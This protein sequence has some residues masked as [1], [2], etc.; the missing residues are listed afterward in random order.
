MAS[1][2]VSFRVANTMPIVMVEALSTNTLGLLSRA[3]TQGEPSPQNVIQV[4]VDGLRKDRGQVLCALY[5]SAD[6]FPKKRDKALARATS[7]ISNGHAACEFREA[8][9]GTYAVSVFHDEN[10]NEKLDTN[11]LGTPCEGVGASNNAKGHLGPP[12]FDQ[13]AF[14]FPG[15]RLVLKITI[16]YL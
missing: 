3:V 9:A 12:K 7:P 13:A 10:S 2:A 1:P 15:G 5:S 6:G 4:D 14:R 8:T 16:N 11:F